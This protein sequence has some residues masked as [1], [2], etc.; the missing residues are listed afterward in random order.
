MNMKTDLFRATLRELQECEGAL[1]RDEPLKE[2]E[3]LA[4]RRLIDLCVNIALDY[5]ED[6]GR[7]VETV[8]AEDAPAPPQSSAVS[9]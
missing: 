6:I 1:F 9:T 4:K 2:G 7:P 5:G 3:A 8:D